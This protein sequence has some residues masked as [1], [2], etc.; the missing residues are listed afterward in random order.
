MYWHLGTIR[1]MLTVDVLPRARRE[2]A[3][4]RPGASPRPSKRRPSSACATGITTYLQN[5]GT[6]EEAQQ[7]AC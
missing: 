6:L 5:G 1:R 4:P 3:A 7:I 2:K